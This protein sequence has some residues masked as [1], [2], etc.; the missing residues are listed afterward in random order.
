MKREMAV[1]NQSVSCVERLNDAY[2]IQHQAVTVDNPPVNRDD[3]TTSIGPR[4]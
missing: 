4:T 1:E 3:G 2:K